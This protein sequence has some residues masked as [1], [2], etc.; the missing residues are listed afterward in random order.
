MDVG[1][2]PSHRKN[3]MTVFARKSN[4]KTELQN[5]RL[6]WAMTTQGFLIASITFLLT[7]PWPPAYAI[8]GSHEIRLL[9]VVILRELAL[10]A[11]PIIGLLSAYIT[12]RGVSASR[13]AIEKV[14]CDWH[15][16]NNTLRIVPE[17]SPQ[18]FGHGVHF[19]FGSKFAVF[20]PVTVGLLWIAYLA[21][22][23]LVL[24]PLVLA[25][26]RTL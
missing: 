8:D 10:F 25:H 13:A 12:Y 4:G 2:P 5:Q 15:K 20:L 21:A 24:L 1:R 11:V 19:A 22:Y 23:I 18:A 6:T 3:I 17:M 16:I 26:I 7:S 9:R 14:K